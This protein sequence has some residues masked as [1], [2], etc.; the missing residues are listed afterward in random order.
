MALLA[1]LRGLRGITHA[2]EV[3]KND[4]NQDRDDP[5]RMLA[6][7]DRESSSCHTTAVADDDD[8]PRQ[9]LADLATLSAPG[10]RDASSSTNED[11]EDK[12]DDDIS[13]LRPRL[14]SLRPPSD[15]PPPPAPA[16]ISRDKTASET[17][18]TTPLDSDAI[19][20]IVALQLQH[21]QCQWEY[22]QGWTA[23]LFSSGPASYDAQKAK[24]RAVTH[25]EAVLQRTM[26][27]A[28]AAEEKTRLEAEQNKLP[29]RLIVSNLAAAADEDELERRFWKYRRQ[30]YVDVGG[31]TL[32]SAADECS[33]GITFLKDRHPL[34]RTQTAHVDMSSRKAAIRASYVM[35]QVY[36]LIFHV[37]LAVETED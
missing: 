23:R 31:F 29:R 13:M 20:Y 26:T 12:E 14:Q 17:A 30:M 36:G 34:K 11:D 9:M 16:S 6:E 25:A 19:P 37:K 10:F 2:P 33:V 8:D 1:E 28:M 24:Q 4:R 21:S 32:G 5:R 27:S 3:Q 18:A 35:G 7:L 22:A 15:E